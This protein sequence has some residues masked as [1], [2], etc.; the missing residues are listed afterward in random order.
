MSTTT[1]RSRVPA[2]SRRRLPAFG[3]VEAL[4]SFAAFYVFLDRATPT[5]VETFTAVLDVSPGA[6]GFATAAL[7]WFV[8]VLTV[9]E[10][11]RR[12]L[13]AAG[14]LAVRPT[15]DDRWREAVAGWREAVAGWREGVP[16][17]VRAGLYLAVLS[18]CG[19]LAAVTFDWAVETGI[20]MIRVVTTLNPGLLVP[21][22]A[23]LLVGFF[24]VFGL[25]AK[26]LDRLV[27]EGL[28]ALVG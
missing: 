20:T 27:V 7:L 21:L 24:V 25:A 17:P 4:V 8:G 23:V 11:V 3:P 5:V 22:D 16:L 6:V 1:T 26:A 9:A 15:T 12:Q 28:R 10:Q 2:G 14:S 13:V 19:T 18:V